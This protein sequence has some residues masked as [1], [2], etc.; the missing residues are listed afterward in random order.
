MNRESIIRALIVAF[1]F[2]GLYLFILPSA[3]LSFWALAFL[4]LAV[5]ATAYLVS[6]FLA[7]KSGKFGLLEAG[8]LIAGAVLIIEMFHF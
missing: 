2:S 5:Q 6:K 3:T 8:V 7:G 1:V 4:L